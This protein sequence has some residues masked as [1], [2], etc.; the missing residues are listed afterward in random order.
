M[1]NNCNMKIQKLHFTE[2]MRDIVLIVNMEFQYTQLHEYKNNNMNYTVTIS[3][4]RT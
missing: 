3:A 1:L 2:L 4:V